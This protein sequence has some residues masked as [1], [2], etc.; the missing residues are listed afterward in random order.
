MSTEEAKQKI[1]E[2]SGMKDSAL[3]VTGGEPTIRDDIIEL[4]DF[5]KECGFSSV[6]LQTNGLMLEDEEFAKEISKRIST[7]LFSLHSDKRDVCEQINGKNSFDKKIK[8]LKNLSE[9]DANIT[10]SHVINSLNYNDLEA[11][12]KHIYHNFKGIG[13]YFSFVRPNGYTQKNQW[14][15][16]KLTEIELELQR[17]LSFC[18]KKKIY[19]HV[20]G[21]PL[22]YLAGYEHYSSELI[23]NYQKPFVY[24]GSGESRHENLH[25]FGKKHLKVKASVCKYCKVNSICDGVWREYS[26]LMGLGE[27]Y[28]VFNNIEDIVDKMNN[29]FYR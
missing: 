5:S 20:E 29:L 21:M 27:L 19:F 16:P 26:E 11:F 1:L 17:A 14:I 22:C 23:R 25:E 8:A 10:I 3:T 12:A 7:V 18:V 28:P 6:E 24:R 4:L 2:L 15:V 13:I 9:L